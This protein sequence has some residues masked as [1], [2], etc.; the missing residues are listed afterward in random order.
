VAK[1]LFAVLMA[2]AFL[3]EFPNLVRRS[4]TTYKEGLLSF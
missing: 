2:F 4:K 1:T 3:R